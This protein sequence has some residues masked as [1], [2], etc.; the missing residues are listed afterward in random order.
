MTIV[1]INQQTHTGSILLRPDIQPFTASWFT[2][3]QLESTTDFE[4][5]DDNPID[6]DKLCAMQK[7]DGIWY[8]VYQGHR[9]EYRE[10][11]GS[12]SAVTYTNVWN[13]LRRVWNQASKEEGGLRRQF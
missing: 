13:T 6:D 11:V 5:Y 9:R 8:V 1:H 2:W 10:A 7:I 3:L 12:S 4:F